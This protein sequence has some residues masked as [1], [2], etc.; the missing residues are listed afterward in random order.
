M[1]IEWIE[2]FL[3]LADTRSFSRAANQR[4]LSQSAFSRRIQALEEWVGVE[5]IDRGSH[6]PSLTPA[7]RA[8]RGFSEGSVRELYQARAL[9]QGTL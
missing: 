6:P 7:G 9:L 4:H 1:E 8:F 3:C 5:L 2:D